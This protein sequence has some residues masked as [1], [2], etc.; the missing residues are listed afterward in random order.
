M[1]FRGI[2]YSFFVAA[3]VV[4]MASCSK[5]PK[6]VSMLHEH[7][8]LVG[9]IDVKQLADK[10]ELSK[11]KSAIE[12]RLSGLSK[13]AR[14]KIKEI[15]DDPV[16][17][18]L[19]LRDPLF[20][21]MDKHGDIRIVGTVYDADDFKS[22]LEAVSKDAGFEVGDKDGF[23]YVDMGG[24]SLSFDGD[25][26]LLSQEEGS[27]KK[28]F[29]SNSN[30]A[31]DKDFIE[32]CDRDGDV[33]LMLYGNSLAEA[34]DAPKEAAD[35]LENM[36]LLYDLAFN[37]GEVVQT[38]EALFKDDAARKRFENYTA[39]AG[40][41]KGEYAP[42]FSKNGFVVLGNVDGGKLYEVLDKLGAIQM[43]AFQMDMPESEFASLI[44]SFD[45]DFA[46]G[47]N[48]LGAYGTG[49]G[50]LYLSMSSDKLLQ[51]IVEV[52]GGELR[53]AG[54][55]QYVSADDDLNVTLGYKNK[56][57][58]ATFKRDSVMGAS[59]LT[60][61]EN[62]KNALS[63]SD[64]QGKGTGLYAFLNF[65]MFDAMPQ[66]EGVFKDF[67]YA[68]AYY[69]KSIKGVLRIVL[70]DKKKNSLVPFVKLLYNM[71]PKAGPSLD[72]EDY[73]LSPVEDDEYFTDDDDLWVD[74]DAKEE[75]LE[76]LLDM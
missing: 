43:V 3:I 70:K 74:D 67:D 45:G 12:D 6:S 61:F 42:Y 64:V 49:N 19:D 58:Y 18:G 29:E 66:A 17:L 1:K 33:Q 34:M 71:A 56:A 36:S 11:E 75:E 65:R 40:D 27:P 41:I 7:P 8:V 24:G 9:R 76:E 60:P 57:I 63:K 72:Y 14:E 4:A 68:E 35:R 52:L 53:P 37:E 46:F 62:A 50:G 28:I 32:M 10:G 54:V 59:Y 47:V 44:K 31:E 69:D 13:E 48:E 2:L 21:S 5:M 55:N 15:L 38:L 25:C 26:F 73:E 23:T 16:Q 20:L 22:F 39:M 30:L 51:K